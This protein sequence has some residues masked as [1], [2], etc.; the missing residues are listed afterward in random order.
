[1][2]E[3]LNKDITYK[4]I[5]AVETSG[6][7][8]YLHFDTNSTGYP[9]WLYSN[10]HT[11]NDEKELAGEIANI[12]RDFSKQEGYYHNSRIEIDT[13]EVHTIGLQHRE[14]IRI[15]I[16]QYEIDKKK[17]KEIV[18][19]LGMSVEDLELVLKMAKA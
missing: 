2:S 10:P 12:I 15:S 8:V 16:S 18:A 1:M 3:E 7:R 11:F 4:V 5:T 13:L 6:R 14:P 19:K 17:A 9:C